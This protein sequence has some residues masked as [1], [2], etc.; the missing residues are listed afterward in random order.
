MG[1]MNNY[2]NLKRRWK[3]L[4][5]LIAAV[6]LLNIYYFFTTPTNDGPWLAE[7]EKLASAQIENDSVII[8]NFRRAR[9]DADGHPREI[10]WSKRS[11]N[12]T[13]LKEVWFG[14][15]VFAS[16][17]LAH[18]F[19]SFDFGNGDPVVISVEARQRPDQ[20][21]SPI[22]GALDNY[23]LIY[24]I[25]DEVDIVG[26]RSHARKNEVYFQPLTIPKERGQK[27]FL[28]MIA[29]ANSLIDTPEFYNTFTSNCT[30][31]ILRDTSVHPLQRY[32]D[33]R[34]I[35]PGFSDR[36]AYKYGILDQNY[37][38]ETLREA[39]HLNTADFRAEDPAFYTKIRASF[40]EKIAGVV[41][42]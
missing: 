12:L 21:Y 18:T 39:A 5:G 10:N 9:Y 29:R 35:L 32:V 25:A 14:I 27:L 34:I 16:P 3:V 40:Y 1:I 13:D 22:A 33:W 28:D 20:S 19:L 2:M 8:K 17:G 38:R 26:V 36:I 6:F 41:G 24:T 30:N 15:S 42:G 23:H 4:Y 11:V 37:S 7:Y 31:S